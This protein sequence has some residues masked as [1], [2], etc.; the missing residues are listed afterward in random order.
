MAASTVMNLIRQ[1]GLSAEQ[2]F[3]VGIQL[4]QYVSDDDYRK[5]AADY[6]AIHPDWI[7]LDEFGRPS[8]TEL[9]TMSGPLFSACR[10]LSCTSPALLLADRPVRNEAED[11]FSVGMVMGWMILG[12]N[13]Y[14]TLPDGVV[15]ARG[16][17]SGPV[18]RLT[19]T[20]VCGAEACA[21]VEG[22]LDANPANRA[23]AFLNMIYY[24]VDHFPGKANISFLLDNRPVGST[25][26]FFDRSK[27]SVPVQQF[28]IVNNVRYRTEAPLMNYR[29]GLRKYGVRV[30]REGPASAPSAGL[31]VWIAAPGERAVKAF[32]IGEG[33]QQYSLPVKLNKGMCQLSVFR[34]R[35]GGQER[36]GSHNIPMS[37]HG[38]SEEDGVLVLS[39]REGRL[40]VRISLLSADR[41][42]P[43]REEGFISLEPYLRP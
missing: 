14:E 2:V 8:L 4:G 20:P 28:I 17:T 38:S 9:R 22:L 31:S 24:A 15:T 1:G 26:L 27:V 40:A 16:V 43:L 13:P 23:G 37:V 29:P 3:D 7:R 12:R 19:P 10:E 32:Q 18:V 41:T 25:T 33:T 36:I 30:T 21:V 42:R 5:K 11:L 6:T 39:V 35:D 34:A